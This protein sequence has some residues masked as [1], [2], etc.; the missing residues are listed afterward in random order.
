MFNHTATEQSY[1]MSLTPAEFLR[2]FASMM[3]GDSYQQAGNLLSITHAD[4]QIHIKLTEKPVRKI[5]LLVFPVTEVKL[6]FQGYDETQIA[7]FMQRFG[8]YFQRGGG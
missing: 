5:A 7:A 1:D 4:R 3:Q 6:T 8:R 2:S